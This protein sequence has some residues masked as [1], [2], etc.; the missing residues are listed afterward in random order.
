MTS[1][2]I[3]IIDD[4]RSVSFFELTSFINGT[5]KYYLS[6]GIKPKEYVPLLSNNSIEYVISIFALWRIS[7]IPIP[8]NT[9]LKDVEILSILKSINISKVIKSQKFKK[10]LSETQSIEMK[11]ES[12]NDVLEYHNTANPYDT[13]VII[14]TSGSSGKPKGVEITNNNLYQSYLSETKEFNFSSTD[15][16][17]TSLPFYHIGG[18]AII[19]RALLSGGTLVLPKSLKQDDIVKSMQKDNP[20]IISFVPTVLNRLI[21]IGTKPNENLRYLFLGGGP[22]SDSLIHSAFKNNWQIVKVY[23]SSET[24]AMV[25]A[26]SGKELKAHPACAGRPLENVKLKILDESKRSVE[27]NTVGEIAIKSN[28]IAKGYLNDISNWN[29]KIHDGYY[30]TGDYGFLDKEN[31]LF[32]VSRREDLIVSGGENIDPR[33]IEMLINEHSEVSESFVFPIKDDEWGQVP[34]AIIVLKKNSVLEK[35]MI[36]KNLKLKIAAFKIPK[37]ILF[38][39]EIPKSALGK[40][41]IEAIKVLFEKN[42]IA[43][44]F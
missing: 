17:L 29:D 36:F 33:E 22:S 18:F 42:I 4:K 27:I 5:A 16:F 38:V 11:I 9:R 13:A 28:A 12:N 3:A 15:C 21:E 8:I 41:N 34:V 6:N 2:S 30:L 31:R 25:T 26:C 35:D 19:N 7:A 37:K 32:V 40:V 44:S 39:T 14:Y 10:Q 24:T 20:T 23:G 1:N 43:G